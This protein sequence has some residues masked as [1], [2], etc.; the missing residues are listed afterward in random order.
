MPKLRLNNNNNNNTGAIVHSVSADVSSFE[1]PTNPGMEEM[2][3]GGLATRS[4]TDSDDAA[5]LRP[6]MGYR[7]NDTLENSGRADER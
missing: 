6:S 5:E 4:R 2:E 7:H 1:A 3:T